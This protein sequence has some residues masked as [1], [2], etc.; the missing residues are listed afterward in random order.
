[1]RIITLEDHFA[2]PMFREKFTFSHAR[3]YN[4]AERGSYLGYDIA[5][6][7]LNLGD[8]RLA[9]MDA[10]GIDLQV[11]SLTMPGCEGCDVE[12][13][14]A[15]ATDANDRLA[16]AIK[17]H[18]SRLAGFASL[19]TANPAAATKELERAV[20]RLGFK[21]AMINGHVRGEF[22]DNKVLGNLRI[23]GTAER[24]NLPASHDSSS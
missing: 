22:L 18:P 20:T 13:A 16:E 4:L 2:T 10:T 1:M 23:C 6:E 19:P 9:A 14:M 12:A 15:M 3:G 11:V 17:T 5:S 8:T 24:A 7:L 21:G